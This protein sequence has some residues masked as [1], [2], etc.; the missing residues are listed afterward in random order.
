MLL[1]G[2]ELL[3]LPDEERA[4]DGCARPHRAGMCDKTDVDEVLVEGVEHRALTAAQDAVDEDAKHLRV[5][6]IPAQRVH[7]PPLDST[8]GR[9][10][11]DY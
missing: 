7:R 6:A 2:D 10:T 1:P 4:G 3:L 8:R 11:G 9:A 5:L